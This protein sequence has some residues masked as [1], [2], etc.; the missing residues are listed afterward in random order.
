MSLEVAFVLILAA[1]IIPTA[2]VYVLAPDAR[3]IM[4]S[5]P[6]S[7]SPFS[8]CDDQPSATDRSS[9]SVAEVGKTYAVCV[10]CTSVH[11]GVWTNPLPRCGTCLMTKLCT[12][13]ECQEYAS[14][15][16]DNG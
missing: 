10:N 1:I 6:P 9:L 2:L 12:C 5:F 14:Q 3:E 16:I 8:G 13:D 7:W 11:K 4:L 15:V